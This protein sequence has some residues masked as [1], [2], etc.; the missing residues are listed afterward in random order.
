[1]ITT[2]DSIEI[3][4]LEIQITEA[5]VLGLPIG[6]DIRVCDSSIALLSANNP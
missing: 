1:V 2:S 6:A 4:M 5:N 3:R